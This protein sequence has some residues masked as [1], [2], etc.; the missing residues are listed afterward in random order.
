MQPSLSST[1]APYSWWTPMFL[2]SITF[3]IPNSPCALRESLL[4]SI[5]L[6]L[7]K[8]HVGQL[9]TF[10]SFHLLCCAFS[11]SHSSNLFTDDQ[12]A[13]LQSAVAKLAKMLK[14]QIIYRNQVVGKPTKGREAA[15]THRDQRATGEFL[16]IWISSSTTSKTG[17]FR[18]CFDQLFSPVVVITFLLYL[19]SA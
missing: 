16:V 9:Q 11:T 13:P 15:T 18:F 7:G 8:F 17:Y 2:W 4:H 1:P 6:Q 12:N 3:W 19:W 10:H 14:P 5:N